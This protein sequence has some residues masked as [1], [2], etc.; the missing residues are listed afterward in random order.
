MT[1]NCHRKNETTMTTEKTYSGPTRPVD[2][3]IACAQKHI[4]GAYAAFNEFHYE[5]VNKAWILGQLQMAVGH[6]FRQY[7]EIADKIRNLSHDIQYGREETAQTQFEEII[8]D[9]DA[10]FQRD[11]AGK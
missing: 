7:T 4:A 1:C 8:R 5:A 2:Q 11:V 6:T 3:C 9:I 10:A